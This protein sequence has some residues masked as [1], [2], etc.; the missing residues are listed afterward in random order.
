VVEDQSIRV[1]VHREDGSYWAHVM[2]WPGC[3]TSGRTLGE[4]TEAIEDAVA[5]YVTPSDQEPGAIELHI[6]E[7]D[8]VLGADRSLTP[9]RELGTDVLPRTP[10]R[11]RDPHARWLFRDF[12]RRGDR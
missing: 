12:Y 6:L 8:L 2:E 5:L 9:A 7:M 11:S 3:F 10:A 1:Q 4:L